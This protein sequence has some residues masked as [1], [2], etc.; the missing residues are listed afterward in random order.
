M[1][2]Y[3]LYT[4]KC[5]ELDG[6]M[7]KIHGRINICLSCRQILRTSSKI[8]GPKMI[9]KGPLYCSNNCPQNLLSQ[10]ERRK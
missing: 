7:E 1:S 5:D 8:I 9:Y 2:L 10:D 6:K 3:T 4:L